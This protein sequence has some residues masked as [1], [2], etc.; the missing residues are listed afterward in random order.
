MSEAK[1]RAR[2]AAN[3]HEPENLQHE[4]SG[5][6]GIIRH[7]DESGKSTAAQRAVESL[8]RRLK[9]EPGDIGKL[10]GK[11]F[12]PDQP[13]YALGVAAQRFGSER[14][15]ETIKALWQAVKS[16]FA[17]DP[18]ALEI[19]R[20]V[21]FA[22][23]LV[24]IPPEFG[25]PKPPLSLPTL[26]DLQGVIAQTRYLWNGYI[27]A[28][29]ITLIGA[30]PGAGKTCFHA[31]L[32]R[33]WWHGLTWPDSSPIEAT[34]EERRRPVLYL[35]SDR[36]PTQISETY[37]AMNVPA[38]SVI[39][40]ADP[41][42][43]AVPMLLDDP[44]VFEMI[45]QAV[46]QYRP[47]WICIDTLTSALGGIDSMDPKR[48]NG[49]FG[50]LLD[51][52]VSFDIPVIALAHLSASG[53]VHGR[54]AEKY[55]EHFLTLTLSDPSDA[56][57][58][59]NLKVKRS[60]RIENTNDLGVHFSQAGWEYGPA[61][62]EVEPGAKSP[63]G[64]KGEM[65]SAA[66]ALI[67]DKAGKTGATQKEL[68]DALA[69]ASRDHDAAKKAAQRALDRLRENGSAVNAGGRWYKAGNQ[70]HDVSSGSSAQP[71]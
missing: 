63:R 29:G 14:N 56:R 62:E 25:G 61:H 20:E 67:L 47:A 18:A 70:P 59:R 19:L 49:P 42:K 21:E 12:Q 34:E 13:F 66:V 10:T 27:M 26:A 58:P 31:D 17:D 60:R 64:S 28:G 65:D 40:L 4:A 68:A 38:D 39:L 69:G 23:G 43:P 6:L 33:R 52:A 16:D 30:A 15:P 44:G 37:A 8:S 55:S 32:H 53:H 35:M 36:R 51:I 46:E 3:G 1:K 24:D 5:P 11:E 7:S 22:A 41:G 45:E 71:F 50:R 9:G 54:Q 2:T 48:V 57:S